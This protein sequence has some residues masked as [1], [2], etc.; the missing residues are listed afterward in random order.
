MTLLLLLLEE[1]DVETMHVIIHG[2][3]SDHIGAILF[4]NPIGA[5]GTRAGSD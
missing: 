5:S 2:L 4:F 1:A 3:S